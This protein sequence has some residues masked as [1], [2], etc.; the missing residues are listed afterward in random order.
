MKFQLAILALLPLSYALP[1]PDEAVKTVDG[2]VLGRDE[3][4][5][6]AASPAEIFKRACDYSSDCTSL[7]G[8]SPGKY[9]GFCKQVRAPALVNNIYQVNGGTGDR[10]CCDY[11]PN[12]GCKNHY[13]TTTGGANR[14]CG[15]NDRGW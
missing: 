4:A 2:K 13:A 1:S 11:G 7:K 9:C 10:S 8:A 15:N 12:S 6:R 14:N 3:I 5:G